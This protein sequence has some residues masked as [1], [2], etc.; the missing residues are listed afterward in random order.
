MCKNCDAPCWCTGGEYLV[1]CGCLKGVKCGACDHNPVNTV[2]DK[3]IDL[4]ELFKPETPEEIRKE[5]L[6]KMS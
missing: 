6:D 2:K 5:Y 3:S 4:N 1:S